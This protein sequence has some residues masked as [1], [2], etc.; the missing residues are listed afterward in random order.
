M[1]EAI[2]IT[3]TNVQDYRKID[4]K[5]N[6]DRFDAF[7]MEAQR[8][9]LRGLLGDALYYAFMADAR[10][11]GIYKELLDGKSYTYNAQTIQYYGLI[12][13]LCYWWLA[14]ATREGDLFHSAYGAIQLVNNSQ[15]SFE[16]SRE[17]ERIAAGYMETAQKY[18]NDTI[19]FL[20]QNATTY[21]LW[22]SNTEKNQTQFIS[23]KI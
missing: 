12:P 6:Q 22:L 15:Q 16:T 9:A 7:A 18:A 10:T 11:S 23:F 2:L 5:F 1:A 14:I 21:P 19:K 8:N 3:I 17:K 4:P 13:L 20:N